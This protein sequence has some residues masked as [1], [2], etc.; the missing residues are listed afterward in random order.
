M[1]LS[2]VKLTSVGLPIT[3]EPGGAASYLINPRMTLLCWFKPVF[4]SVSLFPV[5]Q[6]L[7]W[8]RQRGWAGGEQRSR[9][10]VPE[11]S[12]TER[13]H[14][15][16]SD[17]TLA[18]ETQ[19]QSLKVPPSTPLYHTHCPY[20]YQRPLNLSWPPTPD[21]PDVSR[22]DLMLSCSVCGRHP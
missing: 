20:S 21:N 11:H 9:G 14:R 10:D 13:D 4:M 15:Q 19:A 7:R 5:L 1:C 17:E 6:L 8:W 2:S 22:R 12:A 16:H 3:S 18:H